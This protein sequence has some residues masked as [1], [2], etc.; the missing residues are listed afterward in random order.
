MEAFRLTPRGAAYTETLQN[1]SRSVKTLTFPSKI[2]RNHNI[3]SRLVQEEQL[4]NN[5]TPH[6]SNSE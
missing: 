1:G 4:F 2:R 3:A 5:L 6:Y